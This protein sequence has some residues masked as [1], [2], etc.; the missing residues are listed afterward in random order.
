MTD[1]DILPIEFEIE[2]SQVILIVR[3]HTESC[4]YDD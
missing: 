1:L 2:Y 3:R 4:S